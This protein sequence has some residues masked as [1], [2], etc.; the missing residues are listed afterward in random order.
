M[1]A[2]RRSNNPLAP[3]ST[4]SGCRAVRRLNR[5]PACLAALLLLLVVPACSNFQ[6]EWRQAV[7][8]MPGERP[9]FTGPWTGTW[10]SQPTGHSGKLRA[11]IAPADGTTA[12]QPGEYDFHYHAT[13]A[14]ILRA[15]YRARFE[16]T[17]SPGTPGEFRVVGDREINRR[18]RYQQDATLTAETY[19]ATYDASIDHGTLVLRRP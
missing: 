1:T 18:G 9:D 11:I 19:D 6:R 3:A 16:V 5:V 7:A 13:W 10:H 15:S 8:D 14:T 12:G 2:R 4:P 17:E